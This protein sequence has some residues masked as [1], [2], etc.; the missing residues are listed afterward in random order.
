MSRGFTLLEV[1][2][3]VFLM[4]LIAGMTAIFFANTLPAAQ[5]KAT[6]RELAATIKYAHNL[7]YYKNEEQTLS[8]DLDAKQYSIQGREARAI[9]SGISVIVYDNQI[10]EKPAQE[11]KHVLHFDTNTGTR[12]GAIELVREDRVIKIESDPIMI[13][14]IA[15]DGKNEDDKK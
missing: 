6:A 12:W 14:R 10:D 2:I 4:A 11:G 1:M 15:G 5:H 9:P 7:A 13:A 3:V 8:I